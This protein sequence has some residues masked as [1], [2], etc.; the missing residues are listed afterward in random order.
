MKVETK[1]KVV[2]GAIITGLTVSGVEFFVE[3]ADVYFYQQ[4]NDVYCV[5]KN[6]QYCQSFYTSEDYLYTLE[7]KMQ[8]ASNLVV[9]SHEQ[10]TERYSQGVLGYVQQFHS[11]K[12]ERIAVQMM[13]AIYRNPN[14]TPQD[15]E[16][17]TAVIPLHI[18][19]YRMDATYDLESICRHLKKQLGS[20]EDSVKEMQQ[21][22]PDL[23]FQL[24]E[25]RAMQQT[26]ELAVVHATMR[27][28]ACGR[29][30]IL[31]LL[32]KGITD[33]KKEEYLNEVPMK[34]Q[35]SS[36]AAIMTKM[37]YEIIDPKVVETARRHHDPTV[38]KKELCRLIPREQLADR[39]LQYFDYQQELSFTEFQDFYDDSLRLYYQMKYGV[40]IQASPLMS[41]YYRQAT[42]EKEVDVYPLVLKNYFAYQQDK[43][44]VALVQRYYTVALQV[45][46]CSWVTLTKDQYQAAKGAY[47]RIM[48]GTA[49]QQDQQMN[50]VF[51]LS[52]LK[53]DV[54]RQ[55]QTTNIYGKQRVLPSAVLGTQT[56][57]IK[58]MDSIIRSK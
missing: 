4:A 51:R 40:P 9:N 12:L 52:D 43:P 31:P 26:Q 55:Y 7:K 56:T 45:E 36:Q 10:V 41:A 54:H 5:Q 39:F 23:S 22:Y 28:D 38:L 19:A 3:H 6:E 35:D 58:T 11:P 2:A 33:I 34:Q 20:Y 16:A 47:E 13:D 24:I 21:Q 29:R 18:D 46:E 37:L 14:F 57:K 15:K 48:S 8:V 27:E 42:Q 50:A 17:Y 53:T 1:Q 32:Q 30:T 44:I 25:Q 49:T